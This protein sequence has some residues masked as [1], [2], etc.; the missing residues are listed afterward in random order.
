MLTLSK[1]SLP[2][3]QTPEQEKYPTLRTLED[4]RGSVDLEK[5]INLAALYTLGIDNSNDEHIARMGCW[6]PS[7]CGYC[8]RAQVLQFIRTPPTNKQGKRLKEIFE[9]GHHVHDIVQGRLAKLAPILA[10]RGLNY[11]FQ[12]EV[13]CDRE[14]DQLFLELGIAGTADG[15]VRVWNDDFEQRGLVEVKSQS[16]D[17]HVLLLKMDTAYPNHLMQSHLYAWR[18]KLPIIWVFYVNKNNSK[19]EIRPQLFEEEI[20]DSAILYFDECGSFVDRGELPPR[21]ESWFECSECVYR[22]LCNPL[23][24]R[25][26][27]SKL[28]IPKT[29]IRRR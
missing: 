12:S 9:F 8:R 19:R 16:D 22:T 24:L 28:T 27:R 4:A 21:E 2:V 15:I 20:F 7:S 11:E 14:T 17:R 29:R 13:G 26:K 3:V 6:H 5:I 23:V 18:F 1:R 10:E 25:S